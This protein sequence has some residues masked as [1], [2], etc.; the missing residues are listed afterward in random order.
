MTD[1]E[2]CLLKPTYSKSQKAITRRDKT[3]VVCICG[4]QKIAKNRLIR[5][6]LLKIEMAR[7]KPNSAD[8]NLDISTNLEESNS[9]NNF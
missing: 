5:D 8:T 2:N 3:E 1:D 6:N 4:Q 7:Q 9:L